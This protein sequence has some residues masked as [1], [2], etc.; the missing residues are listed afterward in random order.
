MTGRSTGSI[1]VAMALVGALAV[2]AARP[3]LSSPDPDPSPTPTPTPTPTRTEPEPSPPSRRAAA[4][5]TTST[6]TS[7]TASTT[8]TSTTT[9]PAAVLVW[10]DEFD[11]EAG[12]VPDPARWRFDIGGHGW[13][14][15]Q[16]EFTDDVHARLDGAGRLVI[17]AEPTTPGAEP[18]CW[19]GPCRFV[20]SRITTEGLFS[21]RYGR[22]EVRARL[23]LGD[24]TWPAVWM[25]GS[26]RAEVGWPAS[27]EIDILEHV[28]RSGNEVHGALHGP[29]YSGGSAIVG[30]TVVADVTAVH[31][32][33]V[34]W[35]PD[36]ILWSVDGR[37]FHRVHRDDPQL[38]GQAWPFDQPFHL[39]VNLAIGGTLGGEPST[40]DLGPHRLV[41]DHVRV[42]SLSD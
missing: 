27:G 17:T 23:P 10:A 1:A 34:D 9:P 5:T 32:Y 29:G 33:R 28:G 24:A 16:L 38:G 15:R 7:T 42:F 13:G 26:N 12:A 2:L 37:P 4:S 3:V 20:S 41:V 18:P 21:H 19:Y 35:G 8:T 6:T 22:I 40:A 30:S 36:S 25:L 14:N 39:I 31:T 11:G